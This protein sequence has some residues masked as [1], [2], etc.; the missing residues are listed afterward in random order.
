MKCE[1]FSFAI[2]QKQ[3]REFEL[4]WRNSLPEGRYFIEWYERGKRRRAAAGLTTSEALD[5]ARRQET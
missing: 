4:P 1:S 3:D 5:A 2:G